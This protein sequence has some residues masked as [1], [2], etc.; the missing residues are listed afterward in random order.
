MSFWDLY[1]SPRY[2]T[3]WD[4]GFINLETQYVLCSFP[5]LLRP[6]I[7]LSRSQIDR[8]PGH[9]SLSWMTRSPRPAKAGSSGWGR[10]YETVLHLACDV[11]FYCSPGVSLLLGRRQLAMTDKNMVL[12]Y[13]NPA[14]KLVDPIP[15]PTPLFSFPSNPLI[16][17]RSDRFLL[18]RRV[19]RQI[20]LKRFILIHFWAYD[21]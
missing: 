6:L 4:L 17:L 13:P 19:F 8:V 14:Y 18:F 7:P 15:D 20:G 11:D 9:L 5:W 21:W 10:L 12:S 2:N 1:L 16:L 3:G